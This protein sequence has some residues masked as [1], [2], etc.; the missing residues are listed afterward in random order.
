MSA[1]KGNNGI[2]HVAL[3]TI[4]ILSSQ[5]SLHLLGDGAGDLKFL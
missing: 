2:M 3:T 1:I 5:C 4:D